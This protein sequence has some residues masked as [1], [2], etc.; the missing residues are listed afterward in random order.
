MQKLP[1]TVWPFIWHY[2]RDKRWSMA[3]FLLISLIWAIE[4]SASPYFMKLI[5]DTVV[6]YSTDHAALLQAILLPAAL[7]A[8]MTLL[9]NFTFRLYDFIGLRTFPAIKAKMSQDMF[10]YLLRHSHRYFQDHFAGALTKKIFDMVTESEK[11]VQIIND[12][13][14]PRAFALVIAS[15]MLWEVVDPRIGIILFVWTVL[16]VSGACWAA[17]RAERYAHIVSEC[18]STMSGYF[19]DSISNIMSTKLFYRL[20]SESQRIDGSLRTLVK[21]DRRLLWFNLKTNFFQG[22]A[23][24]ILTVALL[25]CLIDGA[26]QGHV[27]PGDFAMVL[28]LVAWMT[29]V[30]WDIGQNVLVVARSLG[31]CRQALSFIMEPHEV[32]DAPDAKPLVVMHGAIEF[33]HVSHQYPGSEVIFNN[34]SVKIHPG[35]KV[36][37]VGYSGG[38]KST[39]MRLILRLMDIKSGEILID[40]QNITQV[41]KAS[42]RSHIST[43]PQETEMF[44]RTIIENI[45]FAQPEATDE[46]VIDAAK[47]A[48]CDEFI[49][50]L[51]EKYHSIVGERG[52]KLSG[53]QRQRIAI[54]RAFLKNAPILLLDEAT[55]SL[56]TA[57]ERLIQ[58]S[59]H[60]VMAHKTTIVIAHRLSTLKDMDR[61]LFF[62]NGQIVEEGS[63]ENLLNNP[64]G[65]FYRLWH[66]QHS[67]D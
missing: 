13:F 20:S 21:S 17:Y 11:V 51:P 25:K 43:I 23:I 46:E 63:L 12:R 14:Y 30:V 38:G 6:Q 2:W 58:Q 29:Y 64:D 47:K 9:L 42:L 19:S 18:S 67:H 44:H 36:G 55:S 26:V 61:I 5:V 53:G 34:L 62:E 22:L 54:A 3:G 16:F 59:L 31:V 37:L 7:Y 52:V 66:M 56:D 15:W 35:E 8:S 65:K 50:A 60:K 45:R 48:C 41:T 28:N 1:N 33:K 32:V 40:G 10:D 24:L 39:F 49:N 57:T 27:T 4:M